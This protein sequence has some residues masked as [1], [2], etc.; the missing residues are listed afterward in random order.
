M[1]FAGLLILGFGLIGIK[2]WEVDS[3]I[4][5][6]TYLNDDSQRAQDFQEKVF[7]A[8]NR[9]ESWVATMKDGSSVLNKE[10]LAEVFDFDEKIRAATV[11]VDAKEFKYEDV[12]AHL[13]DGLGCSAFSVT[14]YWENKAEMLA[15]PSYSGIKNSFVDPYKYTPDIAS[16]VSCM[17]GAGLC[18]GK[19]LLLAQ[20]V[21]KDF[22]LGNGFQMDKSKCKNFP[23]N[24]T[25]SQPTV[26]QDCENSGG[27]VTEVPA[28]CGAYLVEA[29]GDSS[30]DPSYEWEGVFIDVAKKFN[31]DPKNK[32]KVTFNAQS[33]VER[34]VNRLMHADFIII[35]ASYMLMGL[36]V[37]FALGSCDGVHS[38]VLLGNAS[39]LTVMLSIVLGGGFVLLTGTKVN[40]FV[41]EVCPF[42]ILA[43]GTDFSF[44][45]VDA[46]E[47]AQLSRQIRGDSDD[48][49]NDFATGHNRGTSNG[50][51]MP[52]QTTV[53]DDYF[54]SRGESFNSRAKGGSCC[55]EGPVKPTGYEIGM[56]QE[57]FAE[58]LSES[59]PSIALATVMECVSFGVGATVP[60]KSMKAVCLFCCASLFA[61]L[62][63][64]STVFAC[65]L[66]LDAERALTLRPELPCFGRGSAK[67]ER[68]PRE[69]SRKYMRTFIRDHYMPWLRH[70]SVQ[71]AILFTF[72]VMTMLVGVVGM[73]NLKIEFKETDLLSG[74]SYLLD[75]FEQ[76]D[77]YLGV[78]PPLFLVM[79]TGDYEKE[80]EQQAYR[81][82]AW[83]LRP[84][85]N[86]ETASQN[87][88]DWLGDYLWFNK[89]C[90]AKRYYN[91]TLGT[92]TP[93]F[94]DGAHAFLYSGGSTASGNPMAPFGCSFGQF[95]LAPS[96]TKETCADPG[97]TFTIEKPFPVKYGPCPPVVTTPPLYIRFFA[98]QDP[99]A[100]VIC[101]TLIQPQA[102]R[103]QPQA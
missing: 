97:I 31:A 12:C 39:I 81:S 6:F 100:S 74:D 4:K 29:S 95:G 76:Q 7:G 58:A 9:M 75:Y 19:G 36:Y 35:A 52:P 101:A 87:S 82:I 44:Q 68:K 47:R 103:I 38:K 96:G 45:I 69:H 2:C 40:P 1:G 83:Q 5:A 17:N 102:R 61:N 14:G 8:D 88:F 27:L 20:P 13:Y 59:G 90:D 37:S 78:G 65:L 43:L 72:F 42:L 18:T 33:S 16:M 34:E 62:F 57:D 99:R 46:F 60:F 28:F 24:Y 41:Y 84:D 66:L 54:N 94:A 51:E 22:V 48:D 89:Y 92:E 32:I 80:A 77:D 50:I 85:F 79:E 25:F 63:L 26:V 23:E 67:G 56:M 70:K 49:A 55:G 93:S 11:K 64:Q 98:P 3:D 71:L 10:A 73:L 91:S 30:P 53:D 21:Q 15:S 86:P